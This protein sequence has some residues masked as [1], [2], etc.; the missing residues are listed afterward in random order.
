LY[1]LFVK[2][3]KRKVYEKQLHYFLLFVSSIVFLWGL[4]SFSV[5]LINGKEIKIGGPGSILLAMA[6]L[7]IVFRFYAILS[8]KEKPFESD[9]FMSIFLTIFSS[10]IIL[11]GILFYTLH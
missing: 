7:I 1:V 4:A 10:L 3:E 11:W 5:A 2:K 8:K 6:I 9:K